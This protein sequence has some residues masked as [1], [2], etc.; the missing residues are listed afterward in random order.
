MNK[1]IMYLI[2]SVTLTVLAAGVIEFYILL[3]EG[4]GHGLINHPT[5]L[6]EIIIVTIKVIPIIAVLYNLFLLIFEKT[7]PEKVVVYLTSIVIAISLPYSIFLA[8]YLHIRL[9]E[10]Q[11]KLYFKFAI[12]LVILILGVG[13]ASS[14]TT[15]RSPLLTNYR[16]SSYTIDYSNEVEEGIGFGEFYVGVHFLNEEYSHAVSDFEFELFNTDGIDYE[17]IDF[18][19]IEYD[20]LVE[21]LYVCRN[22]TSNSISFDD[23]CYGVPQSGSFFYGESELSFTIRVRIY[24]DELLVL[25]SEYT[26]NDVY[27]YFDKN[28]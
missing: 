24:N 15:S 16:P 3:S 13:V 9:K 19:L 4:L 20:I 6:G 18:T 12:L 21:D 17:N 23:H 5:V 11:T 14:I 10:S 1:R 27:E 26:F 7:L 8:F 2:L 28:N 22:K 25:E